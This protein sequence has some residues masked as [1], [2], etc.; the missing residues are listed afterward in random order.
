VT[1]TYLLWFLLVPVLAE[2]TPDEVRRATTDT[3][4]A[5]D[6]Q[7]ELPGVKSVPFDGTLPEVR[8][9]DSALSESRREGSLSALAVIARALMW[10]VVVAVAVFAIVWLVREIPQRSFRKRAAAAATPETAAGAAPTAIP[11]PRALAAEGRF[12]E[13]IHVLLLELIASLGERVAP[14]WTSREVLRRLRW[15]ADAK[16][17]VRNLVGRVEQILFGGKTARAVDFEAASGDAERVRDAVA[18]KKAAL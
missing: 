2:P 7:R 15:P 16:E 14:A 10:I 13:A 4:E 12:G 3:Y 9:S 1:L 5:G 6:Y 17:P 8:R 11:A 18:R